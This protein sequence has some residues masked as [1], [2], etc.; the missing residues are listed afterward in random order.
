MLT[1]PRS[2]SYLSNFRP[3]LKSVALLFA[4]SSKSIALPLRTG[5]AFSFSSLKQDSS[6]SSSVSR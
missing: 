3:F 6:S 1:P 5:V 4:S 2:E